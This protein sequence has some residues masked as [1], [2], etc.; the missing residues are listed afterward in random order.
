MSSFSFSQKDNFACNLQVKI[1]YY[2]RTMKEN[3]KE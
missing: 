3:R 1:L 2:S